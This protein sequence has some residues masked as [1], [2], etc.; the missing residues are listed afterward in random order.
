MFASIPMK[1]YSRRDVSFTCNTEE[2]SFNILESK[3][4]LCCIF[5]NFPEQNMHISRRTN[6]KQGFQNSNSIRK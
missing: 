6:L 4:Y 2:E 5:T 1:F 3:S